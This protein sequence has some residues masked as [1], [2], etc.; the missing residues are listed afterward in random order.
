MQQVYYFANSGRQGDNNSRG[1]QHPVTLVNWRDSM[2]WCNAL[3]E[4]YNAQ[5][6]TNYECVYTYSSEIIRDSRD[7]NAAA[8]DGAEASS[9]AKGFRLL[10]S[11]EYELAA[12]YRDGTLWTY[13][14]HASGDDSGACFDDGGILGGMG[15]STVFGDYAVYSSNSGSST[16]AVKSKTNGYNALGLY[17]MSGNVWEWCFDLS[18]TSRVRRGGGWNSSASNLQVGYSNSVSPGY[19]ENNIGFRFARN[20]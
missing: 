19:E 14:D 17:D 13:G 16:A 8:C 5:R 11:D 7:A 10:S 12:R 4:W 6:G 20:Q 3:T 1:I 18:M 15:M 9:T 2:V